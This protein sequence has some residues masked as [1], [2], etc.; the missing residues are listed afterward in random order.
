MIS[1]SVYRV[2]LGNTYMH[3]QEY[4][5]S[6]LDPATKNFFSRHSKFFME[7]KEVW[8]KGGPTREAP[9]GRPFGV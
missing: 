6:I 2:I 3:A 1:G 7:N 4:D 5:P 9:L 8:L